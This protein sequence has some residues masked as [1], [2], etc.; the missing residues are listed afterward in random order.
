MKVSGTLSND[1]SES[2]G[3]VRTSSAE[4]EWIEE[5]YVLGIEREKR[6]SSKGTSG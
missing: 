3:L 2:H 4:E 1:A 6:V 5:G